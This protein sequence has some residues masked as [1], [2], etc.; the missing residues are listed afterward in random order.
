MGFHVGTVELTIGAGFLLTTRPAGR[1]GKGG[2]ALD[3]T[4][5]LTGVETGTE[6]SGTD[7]RSTML[8]Q[9]A[10]KTG[11]S[12]HSAGD[13]GDGALETVETGIGVAAGADS[14][15]VTGTDSGTETDAGWVRGTR[16]P[17]AQVLRPTSRSELQIND[18]MLGGSGTSTG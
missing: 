7:T 3:A 5:G 1:G 11:T 13:S 6:R 18:H 2:F 4:G 12:D 17:V 16:H 8:A 10:L 14:T 9:Q 15:L